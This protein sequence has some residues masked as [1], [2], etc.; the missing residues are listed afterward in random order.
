MSAVCGRFPCAVRCRV[1][2]SAGCMVRPVRTGTGPV[3][4]GQRERVEAPDSTA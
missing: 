2:I 3:D 1:A 4:V